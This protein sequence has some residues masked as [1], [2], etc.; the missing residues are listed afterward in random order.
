MFPEQSYFVIHTT[1]Y[2][3]HIFYRPK[4]FFT[5][6]YMLLYNA[7]Q[8]YLNNSDTV[9]Y[10]VLQFTTETHF[11]SVQLGFAVTT[12]ELGVHCDSE[13]WGRCF[14]IGVYGMRVTGEY[15]QK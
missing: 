5:Q 15:S 8:C 14:A 9:L 7:T 12:T 10:F 6:Y 4:Y 2:S 1:L 13:A 3:L 11:V